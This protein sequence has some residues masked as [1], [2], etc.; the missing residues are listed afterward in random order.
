MTRKI[1]ALAVAGVTLAAAPAPEEWNVDPTHTAVTFEVNHFFTPVKGAFSD[2]DV[3][4]TYDA[5]N[6]ANSSVD[7]RISVASVDTD[8]AD[9]D[10]H[11]LSADFFDAENYPYITFESTAVR[12]VAPGQLVATGPLTIKDETR[13]VEL[14]I[15]LLG[16]QELP[17]DVS[18]MLGGV[19][20]VASF[21]AGTTVDRRDF[22]VGVGN[23]A[24]TFV[25]GGDVDISIAL[26]ANQ[27]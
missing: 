23:W 10:A 13:E 14:T 3:S 12:E 7:A 25:V 24:A 8:N 19:T 9:R 1:I 18:R 20:E 11:L 4:L 26:E 27:S 5:E 2:Y 22:G 16:I 21:R 17:E 15:D 6:P